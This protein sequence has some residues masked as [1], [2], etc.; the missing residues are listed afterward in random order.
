MRRL[1]PI[2]IPSQLNTLNLKPFTSHNPDFP[3]GCHTMYLTQIG[4]VRQGSSS[5]AA[6]SIRISSAV[7]IV[8]GEKEI[9]ILKQRKMI[10]SQHY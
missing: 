3:K 4:T 2:F 6:L 10:K 1:D 7:P 9:N 5:E 8:I